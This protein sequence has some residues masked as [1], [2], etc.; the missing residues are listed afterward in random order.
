MAHPRRNLFAVL[1]WVVWKTLSLVGLPLAK[2]KLDE[3]RTTRR[4]LR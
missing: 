4:G 1:G 2:K 3:R